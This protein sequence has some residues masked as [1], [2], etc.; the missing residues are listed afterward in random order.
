[1]E[2]KANSF[3]TELLHFVFS[4]Q[5]NDYVTLGALIHKQN[6]NGF[7]GR[8]N[9]IDILLLGG[10]TKLAQGVKFAYSLERVEQKDMNYAFR[11]GQSNFA[12]LA[13]LLTF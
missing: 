12:G 11:S 5:I 4:Y 10:H 9:E 2:Y 6:N 7:Y 13:L 1:Y 8:E 3:K